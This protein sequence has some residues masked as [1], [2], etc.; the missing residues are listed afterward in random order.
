VLGVLAQTIRQEK[1]I[2]GIQMRKEEVKPAPFA[3]DVIL[4]LKY[5]KVLIHVFS[6]EAGH[7]II[8]HKAIALLF[9]SNELTERQARKAVPFTT[10]S[11]KQTVG[12]KAQP[13]RLK[14]STV[15]T[16]KVLKKE[17]VRDTRRWKE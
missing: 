3:D 11:N 4:Y 5:P 16:K 7:K 13:K 17:N 10:A 14:M 6:K 1:E 9:T 8:R 2:K 15:K 12:A